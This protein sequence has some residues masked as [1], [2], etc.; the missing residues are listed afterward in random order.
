M[1]RFWENLRRF[2]YRNRGVF[3]A[4]FI[5]VYTIEQV[6]LVL[7]TYF[8]NNMAVF[9]VV[10]SLFALVVLTTFSLH[11]LVMESRIK[12]LE[13]EVQMAIAD[14]ENQFQTINTLQR[15][16]HHLQQI[17]SRKIPHPN[18]HQATKSKDFNKSLRGVVL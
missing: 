15:E 10:V 11:R 9:N 17:K 5:M 18:H 6:A 2:S 7:L 16:Y 12:T 4:A 3:E 8:I 1:D 14:N 13:S